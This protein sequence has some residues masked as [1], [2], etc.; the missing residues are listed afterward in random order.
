MGRRLQ[1]GSEHADHD[2]P[3]VWSSRRKIVH[4]SADR[5]ALIQPGIPLLI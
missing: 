3:L 4:M 1:Q 2:A 5:A